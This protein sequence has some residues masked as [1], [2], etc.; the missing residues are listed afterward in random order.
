ANLNHLVPLERDA[1]GNGIQYK[2]RLTQHINNLL[3]RDSTNV[4]LGLVVSENVN[5]ISNSA[6]RGTTVPE[7]DKVPT[8]TVISPLGTVLYGADAAEEDKRMKLRI[9]YT[10]LKN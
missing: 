7:I 6:V 1:D 3:N 8:S 4:K 9:Y 10:E 5:L 2:M